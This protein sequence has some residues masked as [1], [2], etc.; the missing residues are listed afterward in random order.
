[1]V[2]NPN[3]PTTIPASTYSPCFSCSFSGRSLLSFPFPC[4]CPP[5]ALEEVSESANTSSP[6]TFEIGPPPGIVEGCAAVEIEGI[7]LEGSESE[8]GEEEEVR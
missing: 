7:G 4:P 6:V 1:M 2:D 8:S 5:S 3:P